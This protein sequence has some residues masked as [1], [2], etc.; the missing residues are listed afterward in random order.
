MVTEHNRL[1]MDAYNANPSSTRAA[2]GK[3]RSYCCT[4][5]RGNF[6]RYA[7]A[8]EV[9]Q[10]EHQ[11][12]VDFLSSLKLDLVYLVGP[13]YL[14]CKAPDQYRHFNQSADLALSA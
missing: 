6:G 5:E 13:H 7:G 4:K 9:S 2:L 1:L 14:A 8:C 12:I 11:K 10:E 3:L